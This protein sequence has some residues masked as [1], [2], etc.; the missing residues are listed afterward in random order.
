MFRK[1]IS[2]VA[3]KNSRRDFPFFLLCANPGQRFLWY[4]FRFVSV[5]IVEYSLHLTAIQ[6][7]LKMGL[8]KKKNDNSHCIFII[9]LDRHNVAETLGELQ[10]G[11]IPECGYFLYMRTFFETM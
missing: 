7:S 9:R 3:F 8:V 4:C 10:N 2:V 6:S 5:E 11:S 1:V